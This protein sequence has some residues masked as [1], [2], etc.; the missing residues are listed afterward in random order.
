MAL[1]LG[2][3]TSAYTTSVAL[4][5]DEKKEYT[6]KQKV[7]TVKAGER[8]LRQ[9]EAVFQHNKNLPELLSFFRGV[10]KKVSTVNVS[11]WP[12]RTP[13]SYMPVFTVGAGYGSAIATALDVPFQTFSHQEGH[14]MAAFYGCEELPESFFALHLSG[15]TTELLE[16]QRTSGQMHIEKIGGT[17]DLNFGQL[18]DRIGVSLGYPFPCGKHMDQEKTAQ[19]DWKK[20]RVKLSEELQFNISGLEN[21]IS[22]LPAD[23]QIPVLFQT[24]GALIKDWVTAA[25]KKYGVHP[26]VISGGVAAN[27]VIRRMLA[28]QSIRFAPV[29]LASDNAVGISM[30]GVQ[31]ERRI[32]CK[33][34]QYHN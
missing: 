33:S 6:Q 11:A 26:V 34:S 30:L 15:G 13:G 20:I 8:G 29:E 19:G 2:I 12:R 10:L 32:S 27:S 22:A 17:M 24:I 1:H 23:Q 21:K 31:T 14:V 4:Y 18:I 3:D 16:V 7:L 9:S 28:D 25:Q 5:D